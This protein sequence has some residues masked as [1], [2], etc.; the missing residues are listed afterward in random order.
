M[1]KSFLIVIALSLILMSCAIHTIEPPVINQWKDIETKSVPELNEVETRE[2]GDNLYFEYIK[3]GTFIAGAI[4]KSK[5]QGVIPTKNSSVSFEIAS[6]T[7]GL[8]K[9]YKDTGYKALCMK[10]IGKSSDAVVLFDSGKS[11]TICL[12]DKDKNNVFEAARFD[13]F[14]NDYELASKVPYETVNR[15]DEKLEFTSFRREILYQGVSKGTIKISYREYTNDIA[16]PAFEQNVS[17]DL[18][19]DG[20]ALIAFKG[21]RIHVFKATNVSIKYKV[22]EPFRDSILSK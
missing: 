6:G 4:T 1:I 18:N 14:G 5:A 12:I 7:E 10:G 22:I 15:Y 20:T 11:E 9:E 21:A 16:R 3:R 8:L 2:I 17:Y 19:S 13:K